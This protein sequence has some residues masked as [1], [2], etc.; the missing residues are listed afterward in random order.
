MVFDFEESQAVLARA[1]NFLDGK[2]RPESGIGSVSGQSG[3]SSKNMVKN[4]LARNKEE[5]ANYRKWK[6]KM[7]CETLPEN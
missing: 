3:T 1:E 2:N 6:K 5:A 4:Y 7:V